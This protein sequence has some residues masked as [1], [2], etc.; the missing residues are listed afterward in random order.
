[1]SNC[2]V[3]DLPSIEVEHPHQVQDVLRCVLHTVLFNRALGLVRPR[4]VDLELFNITYVQCVDRNLERTIDEKVNVVLNWM[5][6]HPG[7]PAQVSLR[8]FEKRYK[9][10][11][12]SKQE[13]RLYW[14][15]WNINV[16]C[17][18]QV[19]A[20]AQV[21]MRQRSKTTSIDTHDLQEHHEKQVRL[22]SLLRAVL[23]QILTH[24]NNKKE[25][26]P[27]VVSSD[28]VTFPYEINVSNPDNSQ[29]SLV[30]LKKLL[31]QTK[32][33]QMLT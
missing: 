5:E 9:Q 17:S 10:T 20:G 21:G 30:A 2:E 24:V 22:Q 31:S 8:F 1:M 7:K 13:E 19:G 6:R 11:W 15:Q 4:E 26:I 33:P 32:A 12:F 16:G 14:E 25:H 29:S 23:T 18:A 3:V 27:P 28:A